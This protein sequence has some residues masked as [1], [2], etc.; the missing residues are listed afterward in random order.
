MRCV[1]VTYADNIIVFVCILRLY[2]LFLCIGSIMRHKGILEALVTEWLKILVFSPETLT[3][4]VLASSG[5][6]GNM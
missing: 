6:L 5:A 2:I 3:Y 4:V 1:Y